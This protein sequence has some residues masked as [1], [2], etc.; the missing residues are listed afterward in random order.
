MV[1]FT[2]E[3]GTS[4]FFEEI[5]LFAVVSVLFVAT[6]TVAVYYGS[7]KNEEYAKVEF[8][9]QVYNFV[10]KIRGYEPLL[11]DSVEG[12]YDYH[13]IKGI[14]TED[15]SRDL[16]PNF[17]Y[18]IAIIDESAYP[19]KYSASWSSDPNVTLDNLDS[20]QYGYYKVVVVYPVDIWVSDHEVHAANL[21]VV[22]WK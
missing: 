11:H 14:S 1:Y 21:E 17:N 16:T 8:T 10:Q 15:L 19:I 13:K 22:G 6:L 7:L 9:N 2:K 4:G 12:M 5:M 18:Y 3:R 20:I